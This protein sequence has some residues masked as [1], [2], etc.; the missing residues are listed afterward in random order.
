MFSLQRLLLLALLPV[1]LL[2]GSQKK[3]EYLLSPDIVERFQLAVSLWIPEPLQELI[4]GK[5]RITIKQGTALGVTI[6]DTLRVPVDSFRGI[7]YA[8][9]P[10][11]K[12]DFVLQSRSRNQTTFLTPV[13]LERGAN[14]LL[15]KREDKMLTLVDVQENN[16]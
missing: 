13:S 16:C 14:H 2:L 10:I 1:I 6:R 9:P 12:G 15:G 11:G 7:P 5:P 8:L 3:D 4:L